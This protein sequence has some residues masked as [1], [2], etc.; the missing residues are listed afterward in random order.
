M[1]LLVPLLLLAGVALVASGSSDGGDDAEPA[2]EE[3][4]LTDQADVHTGTDASEIIA[5][6]G[7]NDFVNAGGGND[8]VKGNAGDDVLVGGAGNDEINGAAG[9]DTIVSGDLLDLNKGSFNVDNTEL[10]N[11]ERQFV[12]ATKGGDAGDDV[13]R[14]GAGND[15][16]IDT[17]G[18]NT[19]HGGSENDKIVALD[20]RIGAS[21]VLIGGPGDDLLIADDGDVLYGGKGNDDYVVVHVSGE[22]GVRIAGWQPDEDIAIQLSGTNQDAALEFDLT[23]GEVTISY[24]GEAVAKV[25][26]FDDSAITAAQFAELQKKVTILRPE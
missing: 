26:G 2:R 24:E 10:G 23:N 1:E 7:G 15:V 6:M 22:Q 19:F 25:E 5:A 8:L 9:N 11:S 17:L 21:D 16:L 12:E 20:Q 13:L 18:S 3:V 14:G 4:K